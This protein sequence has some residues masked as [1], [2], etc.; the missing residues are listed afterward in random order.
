MINW[1][2]LR[3]LIAVSRSGSTLAA[4]RDIGVNQSTVH[5]RL[6]ELERRV[7]LA[8][9]RRHPSGYRLTELG[10]MLID[11]VVAVETAVSVFARKVQRV[12]LDLSGVIRLTCPEPTVA[13]I[14]ESGFLDSFG[15]R[16]PNLVVEFVT[17]DR[18][19]DLAKGEADVAFRSGEPSDETLIGRRICDSIWAIYASKS[20]IQRHG[21]PRSVGELSAHAMI[22]FEGIMENHRVA[23]WLPQAVPEARVVN[24]SNSMLGTVS[25][26]RAGLGIAP[27][28]TTLGDAEET[29]VQILPPIPELTRSWYLLSNPDARA[30]PRVGAF[31]DFAV[32]NIPALKSALIG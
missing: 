18:Y 1:N 16:Y 30:T 17:S 8:L 21:M 22:G 28:P 10:E 12:A 6:V 3:Y 25:A 2:D 27:L 9:V 5:R 24:R 14:V 15:A 29:L 26:A 31:I 20:Y 13:R 19:L 32:D 23:K 4:A 11:E 7:N